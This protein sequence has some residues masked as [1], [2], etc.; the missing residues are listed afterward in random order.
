MKKLLL[1]FVFGFICNFAFSRPGFY[2]S[3]NP[4][5]ENIHDNIE[6]FNNDDNKFNGKI[7]LYSKYDKNIVFKIKDIK[8]KRSSFNYV[9]YNKVITK[10]DNS[11][12]FYVLYNRYSNKNDTIKYHDFDILKYKIQKLLKK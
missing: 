5:N 9:N 10:E 8:F 2:A 4:V 11:Y 7:M 1:L 6:K 12:Y 3:H